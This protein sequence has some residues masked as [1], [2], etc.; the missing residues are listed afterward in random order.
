MFT[1]FQSL[2]VRQLL[3][4]QAPAVVGSMLIAEAFYKF[5]SF[6]L[7]VLAFLGTWYVI[8]AAIKLIRN[9]IKI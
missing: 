9:V 6:T 4:E 1:L 3:I 8:N 2:S 7:E 5:G